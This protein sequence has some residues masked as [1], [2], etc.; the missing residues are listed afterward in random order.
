MVDRMY[1]GF[2]FIWVLIL[3]ASLLLPIIKRTI[4]VIRISWYRSYGPQSTDVQPTKNRLAVDRPKLSD[5]VLPA[6]LLRDFWPGVGCAFFKTMLF[7]YEYRWAIVII[8]ILLL[9]ALILL[10]IAVIILVL[11]LMRKQYQITV[12]RPFILRLIW[13]SP[14][15]SKCT[16]L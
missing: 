1:F 15:L 9:L 4:K 3:I 13:K 12:C 2:S 8:I 6:S 16:I 7:W 14:C 5:E 10:I 11:P